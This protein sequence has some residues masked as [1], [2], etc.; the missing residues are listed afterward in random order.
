M[1]RENYCLTICASADNRWQRIRSGSNT[2]FFHGG[3]IE[4]RFTFMTLT[5]PTGK[6]LRS[7]DR[8]VKGR[9]LYHCPESDS[10]TLRKK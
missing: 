10:S 6:R 1:A 2:F 5:L 9:L 8:T 7:G 3:E 4:I